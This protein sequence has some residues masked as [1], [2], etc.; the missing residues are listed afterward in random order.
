MHCQFICKKTLTLPAGFFHPW[1]LT[2]VLNTVLN[3]NKKQT[4]KKH[5]LSLKI[6]LLLFFSISGKKH[7]NFKQ[8][9]QHG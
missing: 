8:R 6:P 3:K 9:H 7:I 2:V 4:N 1:Q 5:S